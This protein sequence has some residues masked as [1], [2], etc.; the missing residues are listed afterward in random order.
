MRTAKPVRSLVL[1][2]GNQLDAESSALDGFDP[3]RDVMWMAEVAEESEHVWTS[4]PR[5]AVFL[6]AMRHFRDRLGKLGRTV[7]YTALA[8]P[9]NTQSLPTELARTVAESRPERLVMTEAGEWRVQ[10]VINAAAKAAGVPLEVRALAL[11]GAASRPRKSA[12]AGTS[13]GA[14]R[15]PRRRCA[16]TGD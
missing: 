15:S 13:R 5:I 14:Q 1:V 8:D 11:A 3:K 16:Q 12:H 9:A 7:R 4:K 10:E 6:S 2:L